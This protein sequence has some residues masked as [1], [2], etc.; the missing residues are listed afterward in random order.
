MSITSALSIANTGLAAASRRANVV[1]NNIANALTPGYSKRSVSLSENVLAGKGA[2]VS[3]SAVTRATDD[4]LTGLRRNA[5]SSFGRENIIA[6]A[7]ASFNSAIGQP[8]D[9]FSLFSQF[10]KLESSLRS[11]SQTPESQAMHAAVLD[12]AKALTNTFHRLSGTVQA[13]RQNADAQIGQQVNFVNDALVQVE[14]LNKQISVANGGGRDAAGLEDQRKILI[15]Q[16]SQIIPVTEVNRGRGNIDLITTEGVF[17]LAGKARTV[18]FTPTN[19]ITPDLTYGGGALS[20]LSVEGA[21]ITPGGSS[22]LAIAQGTLSGL[23]EV[24]DNLAPKFQAQLD[25]LSQDLVERFEGIDPTIAPGAPGLFTDDGAALDPSN[26]SGLAGRIAINDAIDPAKGGA[27]W[28]LRDGLG[29][30]S[31][32]PSGNAVIVT[33][34][35]DAFTA[36]KTIPAGTGISGDSSA[37]KAVAGVT[38]LIGVARISSESKL[39]HATAQ[40]QSL[41]EAE[42]AATAV[43]TDQELQQLLVIEQA[44][45]ANARV[46]Q[47]ADQMLQALLEL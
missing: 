36:S 30:T 35:L 45:S 23:F 12:N 32:G 28:R 17:L 10:Q 44:F 7:H 11:L 38:S 14:H 1:S 40:T 33:A 25:G 37:A 5:E 22:G 6:S 20:G 16:I 26:T 13:T 27:A 41:I 46:I 21:N 8:G 15:D 24:R 42:Q 19:T 29:A 4:G 34:M 2:G 3:V 43:D 18:E 39:A 31:E 47:S 9:Q